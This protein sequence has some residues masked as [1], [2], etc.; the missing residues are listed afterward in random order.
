MDRRLFLAATVE[1][2]AGC[3]SGEKFLPENAQEDL[4]RL[5]W[6]GLTVG[7]ARLQSSRESDRSVFLFDFDTSGAL[8]LLHSTHAH[9]EASAS[10]NLDRSLSYRENG[11][12]HLKSLEFDWAQKRI[13]RYRDAELR[14][15]LPQAPFCLDPL[16]L[17]YALR[18]SP[19]TP[20]Q[21][22]SFLLT[23]GKKIARVTA[24][25][26]RKELAGRDCFLIRPDMAD[27]EGLLR[28]GED[29]ASLSLW[30]ES[31]PARRL[32]RIDA[33]TPWGEIRAV[34]ENVPPSVGSG[35]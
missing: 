26:E 30:I 19:L 32:L 25:V 9:I 4:Y 34:L 23:D 3:S 7:R 12:K 13:R 18:R 16:S 6:Q 8:G 5:T 33:G 22:L 24:Q 27:L 35:P 15:T 14:Q 10:L 1:F 17:I 2:F 29:E 20:G 21:E 31:S 28:L 11:G